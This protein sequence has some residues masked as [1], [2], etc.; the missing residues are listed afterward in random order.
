MPDL[1]DGSLKNAELVLRSYGLRLGKIEYKPDLASNAVLEQ[2]IDGR[3][4]EPGTM[5]PLG[6]AIDLIVGDGL[7][8]RV[9]EMPNFLGLELEEAGFSIVGSGLTTGSVMVQVLDTVDILNILQ[10]V[11]EMKLETDTA[12]VIKTG[13]VYRQHPSPGEEVRLGEQVDLWVVS[14]SPEDSFQIIESWKN[15]NRQEDDNG[16]HIN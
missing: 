15:K 6:T 14:R 13:H 2:R 12:A 3:V 4:V 16:G 5:V 11:R 8:N 9:F 10:Q 1:I 7:G